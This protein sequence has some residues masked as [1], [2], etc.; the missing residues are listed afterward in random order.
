MRTIPSGLPEEWF[1]L[2]DSEQAT[3]LTTNYQTLPVIS[4]AAAALDLGARRLDSM[5]E[6]GTVHS[7]ALRETLGSQP[8]Q[9]TFVRGYVDTMRS[10]VI[11]PD[12]DAGI[13]TKSVVEYFGP[14]ANNLVMV[15]DARGRNRVTGREIPNKRKFLSQM[16]R[17]AVEEANWSVELRAFLGVQLQ[18]QAAARGVKRPLRNFCLGD[19]QLPGVADPSLFWTGKIAGVRTMTGLAYDIGYRQKSGPLLRGAMTSAWGEDYSVNREVF[20]AAI[21]INTAFMKDEHRRRRIQNDVR[22]PA[23]TL[24]GEGYFNEA[25]DLLRKAALE[26]PRV[27][28]RVG[29]SFLIGADWRT[30]LEEAKDKAGDMTAEEAEEDL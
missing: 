26:Y 29:L 9:E 17:N 21:N 2:R 10:G 24:I 23:I 7:E 6:G 1:E 30:K 20:A 22:R 28:S 14:E 3:F 8:T 4:F 16:L 25:R 5:R 18:H 11:S 15:Y 19:D 13:F 27:F 12:E